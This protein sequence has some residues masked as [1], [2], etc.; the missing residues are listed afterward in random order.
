MTPLCRMTNWGMQNL[1]HELSASG[2]LPRDPGPDSGWYE[3]VVDPPAIDE[4][5]M[6]VGA[7][8]TAGVEFD[9]EHAIALRE[10]LHLERRVAADRL[11][12]PWLSAFPFRDYTLGRWAEDGKLTFARVSKDLAQNTLARLWWGAENTRASNPWELTEALAMERSDDEFVFTRLAFGSYT[13]G[14]ELG[15]RLLHHSRAATIAFI[16]VARRRA[17]IAA[18]ITRA[19]AAYNLALSTVMVE[20]FDAPPDASGPYATDPQRILDLV[21]IIEEI[22]DTALLEI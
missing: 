16:A 4:A 5:M 20:H 6:T 21:A 9:A 22:A 8:I 10:R 14:Y 2:V 12:W 18:Q 1:A 13:L 19:I 15:R 11:V 17:W 7:V 3:P